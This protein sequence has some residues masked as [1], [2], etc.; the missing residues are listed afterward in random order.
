[1]K[2]SCIVEH[3]QPVGFWQVCIGEHGLDFVQE[4][5]VQAFCNAVVLR[6]VGS[7]D[8]MLDAMLLK[9][10]LN[11]TSHVLAPSVRAEDLQFLSHFQFGSSDKRFEQFANFRFFS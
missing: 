3:F 7:S 1:V 10:L 6:R 2:E 4:S 5:M 11:V 8:F 9:E